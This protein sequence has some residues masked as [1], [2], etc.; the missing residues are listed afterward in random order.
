MPNH[1]INK[2]IFD[3]QH[4]DQVF[5]IC[6]SGTLDFNRLVPMPLHVYRGDC[7]QEDDTDFKWTWYNWSIENWGTKWNAYEGSIKIE[8]DKAIVLFRTAWSVPYPI[9]SAFANRFNICFEHKYF[10]EGEGFWG[11]EKWGFDEFN[12]EHIHRTIKRRSFEEDKKSLGIELWGKGWFE[13][14]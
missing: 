4:A 8:G 13:E 9:I 2:I 3:K 6:P 7:T 5:E 12:R 14:E 11:V 1:V 10:D